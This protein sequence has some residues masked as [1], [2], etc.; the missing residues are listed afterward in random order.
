[1]NE[2]VMR[3]S[4][5]QGISLPE[6]RS[7]TTLR[8]NAN[9][10]APPRWQPDIYA[11][12]FVPRTLVVIN[13]RPATTLLTPP[14]EGIEF[15]KYVTA[16][17]SQHFR[18]AL[19]VPHVSKWDGTNS[20]QF[21][22]RPGEQ[23]YEAD[24]QHCLMLDVKG[25]EEEVKANNMFGANL[26]CID[27]EAALFILSVPGLR[28]DS[29]SVD[30]GDTVLLRQW[31]ETPIAPLNL[32]LHGWLL[33]GPNSPGFTGYEVSAVVVGVDTVTDTLRIRAYGLLNQPQIKCNVIFV[34]QSRHLQSMQNALINVAGELE[35]LATNSGL[36]EPS[37]IEGI[38]NPSPVDT[39]NQ[40]Q[41]TLSRGSKW[42]Q[43]MLFPLKEYGV[44]REGL[45]SVKFPQK[46]FDIAL[47]YEQK[48]AVNAITARNYGQLCYL[49]NGPPG[50]GKTK[51]ICETVTQLG[52]RANMHGSMLVCAPSKQAADTL[53][54]RL[55][56]YF[57]PSDMLRLNHFSRTFAE[58]PMDI[59]MYCFVEDN[60]FNIPPIAKLMAY[61]IVVT[62]CQDADILI[63]ARVSNR[64]LYSLQECMTTTFFL[65]QK[66]SIQPPSLHWSALIIDEAAQATE[67]ETLIPLS[68]VAP[69]LD[70]AAG[71]VDPIF[72]MAGDQ[73]QLGPR[74]YD[75]STTLH[76]SLFERLSHE[77]MYAEHPLARQRMRSEAKQESMLQPPFTN[78]VR[79]YRSHAAILAVP[80]SLF[81]SNTL[82]P[83]AI[84]SHIISKWYK[85]KAPKRGWPV[86]FACNGGSDE[87]ENVQDSAHGW[88]NRSEAL[89]AIGYAIDI[90]HNLGPLDERHIC[91]MSPFRAQVRLLRKIAREYNMH[92]INIG[93][94]EAF[95]GL[96]SRIVIICTTRARRRFLADDKIRGVGL[97]GE[98]KKFN[99]AVTRAKE[100][101]VVIG[102]PWVLS[103]DPFWLAFL[104][105]CWRN[106]L[107]WKDSSLDTKMHDT[108][109]GRVNDWMPADEGEAG[110]GVDD[111][112]LEAALMY[113]ERE[114]WQGSSAAKRFL[115][116]TEDEQWRSG[117][118]AE[119]ILGRTNDL[120]LDETV[121]SE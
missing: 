25:Q 114:Q 6:P 41:S 60:I 94:M 50:T 119:E 65:H 121:E 79:N 110:A 40:E 32:G 52:R 117:V 58:V 54:Q 66:A 87:C 67:P 7:L 82:I 4:T 51:T 61:R 21:N 20:A 80:S 92:K 89:K 34:R 91:I 46:W 53:T 109:E 75:S 98:P 100:V 47:N 48:K 30:F 38:G 1:M 8:S 72:V 105:F 73:Y 76:V 74:T 29:P 19:P 64:D 63:Q 62:T 118:E 104:K 113:K 57:G 44:I 26:T 16:L 106:E 28:E 93:P 68:L 23:N 24:F 86:Q 12:S 10:E 49:I 84:D 9:G 108:P 115:S 15:E 107:F 83:E 81:Y 18:E 78:L 35:E 31:I 101:L 88:Y 33:H 120:I 112:G 22:G 96:E 14:Q 111:K 11:N 70:V 27:R 2:Y 71:I 99:V 97:V 85:W 103:I 90:I 3:K 116:S 77:K 55:S 59:M 45:P 43:H 69:P 95:Q 36:M 5:Y 37:Q 17:Y 56:K 13:E 39:W 102:N 42:L